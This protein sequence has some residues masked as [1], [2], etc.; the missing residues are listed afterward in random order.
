ML[1][2]S[3]AIKQNQTLKTQRLQALVLLTIAVR[4]PIFERLPLNNVQR[5]QALVLL[6]LAVRR[7]IFTTQL[8]NGNQRLQS[9]LMLTLAVRRPCLRARP[10]SGFTG[11]RRLGR[12]RTPQA[13]LR[14]PLG[15][16]GGLSGK[17]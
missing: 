2:V 4:R 10:T 14:A 5:H 16:A 17:R 9:L 1:A 11:V 6:T 12:A 3:A 7:P 13:P 8:H 15:R